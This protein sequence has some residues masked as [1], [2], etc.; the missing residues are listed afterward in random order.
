MLRRCTENVAS[1][2]LL[3]SVLLVAGGKGAQGRASYGGSC[4]CSL[5]QGGRLGLDWEPG[6]GFYGPNSASVWHGQSPLFPRPLIPYV[7][8]GSL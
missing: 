2:P 4:Q 5:M 8:S 7:Q 3:T 6:H 1:H